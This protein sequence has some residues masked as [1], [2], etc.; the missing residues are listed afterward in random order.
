MPQGQQL[1]PTALLHIDLTGDCHATKWA[2][3]L[4]LIA[5]QEK[6]GEGYWEDTQ[7]AGASA[8]LASAKARRSKLTSAE[9]RESDALVQA[10][11]DRSSDLPPLDATNRVLNA[12]K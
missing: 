7:G 11:I 8:S 1:E 9:L 2:F 6:V 5:R 12:T 3:N 4:E 10:L